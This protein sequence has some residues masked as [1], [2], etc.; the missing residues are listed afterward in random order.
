MIVTKEDIA[1]LVSE[2]TRK[3]L[4]WDNSSNGYF[5]WNSK[6][7]DRYINKVVES[8]SSRFNSISQDQILLF[9]STVVDT[10]LPS[11]AK[12]FLF[13]PEIQRNRYAPFDDPSFLVEELEQTQSDEID[14]LIDDLILHAAQENSVYLEEILPYM[15]HLYSYVDLWSV[16]WSSVNN[17]DKEFMLLFI[18]QE[19]FEK[20]YKIT[21]EDWEKD[22]VQSESP[23]AWLESILEKKKRNE[24]IEL[25]REFLKNWVID[26]FRDAFDWIVISFRDILQ[27]Y[28]I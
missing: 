9:V 13:T 12:H 15:S 26:I 27:Y 16:I 14:K 1:P 20:D 22:V 6:E 4:F 7:A 19:E 18:P 10:G 28:S 5:K 2:K 25:E 3:L 11:Y 23:S 17:K 8:L 24:N 21:V